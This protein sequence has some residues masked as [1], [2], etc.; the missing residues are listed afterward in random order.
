MEGGL[1]QIF[2]SDTVRIFGDC[3]L[4]M[5]HKS[6]VNFTLI[7]KWTLPDNIQTFCLGLFVSAEDKTYLPEFVHCSSKGDPIPIAP[8]TAD[9]FVQSD[10]SLAT[11]RFGGKRRQTG[12]TC[13]MTVLYVAT[14]VMYYHVMYCHVMYFA[15]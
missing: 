11:V 7:V 15:I 6:L 8:L 3:G 13:S 1:F 10:P 5:S 2:S 9:P 12:A 4:I 14:F